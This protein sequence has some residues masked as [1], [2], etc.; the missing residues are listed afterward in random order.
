MIPHRK[1]D[2][3][4]E[5]VS[6]LCHLTREEEWVE[7]KVD[8]SNPQVIG[9]NISALSNGAALTG[10]MSAYVV[11]GVDDSTHA[12]VGTN[13]SPS[14]AKKGNE[15]LESWLLRLLRPR[16]DVHFHEIT[17]DERH[18]VLLEIE[19]ASHQPVAFSG[20]EFIRVGS[21]TKKL[22][23]YPEK[24]RL[25]WRISDWTSFENGVV[26][27]RVNDEDILLKLDY[28]TFFDLL[29]APL[30]DGRAA[31]LAALQRDD[32]ISPCDAGG[33]N[34][35]NMGAVLLAKRLDE[36]TR[37]RRKTV[38]IIQYRGTGRLETLKESE[39]VA[40]Y[41]V[42]FE[43]MIDYIMAL[44]P[45]NEVIEH[46]LRKSAPMF[47]ELAVRELV[48]NALIHQDFIISGAGPMVEIFDDRIEITNPGKP[49]VDTKRFIDTPPKSRNETLAA[50][51]RRFGICEERGS[52]IDKVVEQTENFQLPGPLFEAP[53]DFTRAV[54]FAH[55][56]LSEMDRTERVRVCYLHTCLSGLRDFTISDRIVCQLFDR[57]VPVSQRILCCIDMRPMC[58][59]YSSVRSDL[60]GYTPENL[61]DNC[62]MLV[63]KSGVAEWMVTE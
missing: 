39:D 36:F 33:W 28:P 43:R 58:C 21:V 9:E 18:V 27:E 46:S 34:I 8:N 47:P 25:L 42:G 48:A 12:I 2:Y 13:F 23:E 59:G 24:E 57:G 40:G 4:V 29:G 54:L 37:L 5:L 15:P 52:G 1:A 35:S 61:F 10:K 45:S 56:D 62:L 53:D 49:L 6:E 7:F 32:L 44:V 63:V 22:S 3:L 20:S 30:P 41:A 14:M 31:I 19:P 50:L 38:R 26:A 55:K 11:W 60:E 51:M 16:I 17:L